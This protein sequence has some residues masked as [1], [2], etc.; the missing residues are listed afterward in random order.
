MSPKEI[1][2]DEVSLSTETELSPYFTSM[3][4]PHQNSRKCVSYKDLFDNNY[5]N[6]IIFKIK[7]NTIKYPKFFVNI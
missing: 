7:K 5:Y 6:N 4:E 2:S 1:S 3:K